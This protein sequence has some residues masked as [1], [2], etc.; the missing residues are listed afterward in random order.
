L[1][2]CWTAA[3]PPSSSSSS[4][5]CCVWT[6]AT[7]AKERAFCN[8]VF[9]ETMTKS[10]LYLLVAMDTSSSLLHEAAADNI[11]VAAAPT[12]TLPWLHQA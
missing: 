9:E 8:V 7:K 1:E 4:Q 12:T 3:A 5:G 6:T 2:W 11:P 10:S